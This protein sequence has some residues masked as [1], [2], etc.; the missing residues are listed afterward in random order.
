MELG[1]DV[2]KRVKLCEEHCWTAFVV[3]KQMVLDRKRGASKRNLEEPCDV[4]AF[5]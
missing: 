2:T 5:R 1:L 3:G 4:W